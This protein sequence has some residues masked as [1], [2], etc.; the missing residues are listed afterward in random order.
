MACRFDSSE[1]R[2]FSTAIAFTK[3]VE[4][5]RRVGGEARRRPRR[6]ERMQRSVRAGTAQKLTCRCRWTLLVSGQG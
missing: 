2:G 1:A 4:P 3:R 5:A 6:R